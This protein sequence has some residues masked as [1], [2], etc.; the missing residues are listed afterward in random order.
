MASNTVRIG[1]EV[2]DLKPFLAR[3][4]AL[5]KTA[6]N[7]V[8]EAAQAIADDEAERIRARGRRV[9]PLAALAASS[10]KSRR[11][12]I[13]A[14]AGGGAKRIGED[15]GRA[16]DLFFG[17]EFGGRGRKTTQQFQPHRGRLGYFF[18]DQLREDQDRMLERWQQAVD[19]IAREWENA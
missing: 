13:P 7:E 1:V 15:G 19:A 6:Q 5:P 4:R 11:D 18:F 14:I 10:V 2:D 9:S 17:A 16:G 12:R 8:R 3:V